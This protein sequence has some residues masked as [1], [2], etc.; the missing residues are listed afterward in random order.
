MQYIG[1]TGLSLKACYIEHHRYIKTN[2]QKSAYA[3]HTLNNKHEYGPLQS[4]MKLLINTVKKV[5][6]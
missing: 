3:L 4:T 2:E 6:T 5:G 1:Q